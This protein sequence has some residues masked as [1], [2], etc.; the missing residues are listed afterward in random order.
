ML[1]VPESIQLCKQKT[2]LKNHFG[3]LSLNKKD[4]NDLAAPTFNLCGFP[5]NASKTKVLTAFKAIF[6]VSNVLPAFPVAEASTV[7][8][9]R[10]GKRID[11]TYHCVASY[12]SVRFYFFLEWLPVLLILYSGFPLQTRPC[13]YW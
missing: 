7:S 3:H 12:S 2:S 4:S 8:E 11:N 6:L 1:D 10:T 13:R 5:V 9:I